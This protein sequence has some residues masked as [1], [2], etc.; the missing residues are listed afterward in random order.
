M[1]N[2]IFSLTENS[3]KK[4]FFLACHFLKKVIKKM[5]QYKKALCIYI[6]FLFEKEK[7]V[8]LYMK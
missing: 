4:I 1:Y 5:F 3:D 2:G 8:A 6:F 7:R